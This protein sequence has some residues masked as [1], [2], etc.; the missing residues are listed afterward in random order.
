VD[1]RPMP[2]V[3]ETEWSEEFLQAMVTAMGLSYFKY[4]AVAD[5]YPQKVSALDSLETRLRLYREGGTVKGVYMAPGN[6]RLLADIANFAMIEYLAPSMV[7]WSDADNV[8]PGREFHHGTSDAP[9][10]T[11]MEKKRRGIF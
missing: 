1:I 7:Q 9:N 8:S 3:P 2:E 11:E 10:L 4:G 6:R 5:A